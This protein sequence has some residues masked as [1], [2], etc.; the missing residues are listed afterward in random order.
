MSDITTL[1]DDLG[2]AGDSR[3]KYEI[4]SRHALLALYRR[5]RAWQVE[6]CKACIKYAPTGELLANH[7]QELSG[8]EPNDHS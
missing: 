5:D 8:L 4:A 1:E 6:A 3:V 2:T 7:T